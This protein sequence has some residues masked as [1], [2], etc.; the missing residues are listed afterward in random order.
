[1]QVGARHV[2]TD[3]LYSMTTTGSVEKDVENDLI[4]AT[5]EAIEA[6]SRFRE[7]PQ[8][9]VELPPLSLPDARLLYAVLLRWCHEHRI[10]EPLWAEV[11]KLRALVEER[12]LR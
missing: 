10:E 7:D 3:V 8:R 2:I 12:M 6:W 4:R 1:V 5:P 11:D 9:S